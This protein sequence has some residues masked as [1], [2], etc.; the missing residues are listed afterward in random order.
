MTFKQAVP[1]AP[2]PVDDAYCEGVRALKKGHRKCVECSDANRLTGSVDLDSELQQVPEHANASRWDYGIGYRPK[3]GP[4]QA[5]WV[6]VHSAKASEVSAV[7]KQLQG[8]RVW[9]NG[10]GVEQ[11]RQMTDAAGKDIR[12]VWVA[13]GG[14][15]IPRNSRQYQQLNMS[16]I[17]RAVRKLSL[18]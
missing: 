2:S 17:G 7:L 6:E 18:P 16:E 8:L 12:F 10:E 11:L 13:S 15:N 9:P 14:A 3:N 4:E 1:D 5:V